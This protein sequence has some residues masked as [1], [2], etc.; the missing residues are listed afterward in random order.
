[1][2]L[3]SGFDAAAPGLTSGQEAVLDNLTAS[4][5]DLV[6]AGDVLAEGRLQAGDG[7]SIVVRDTTG[8]TNRLHAWKVSAGAMAEQYG[9]G[10]DI[11][12]V[13]ASG[14]NTRRVVQTSGENYFAQGT[15]L[16]DGKVHAM[17]TGK[18]QTLGHD[19]GTGL[20]AIGGTGG[21]DFGGLVASGAGAASASDDLATKAQTGPWEL[22][23]VVSRLTADW[24]TQPAGVSKRFGQSPCSV[25]F[26]A[27]G[28]TISD[29]GPTDP[30]DDSNVMP[31]VDIA[32]HS[33][34]YRLDVTLS[35]FTNWTSVAAGEHE[36][37]MIIE[38]IG[39]PGTLGGQVFVGVIYT[40]NTNTWT[41]YAYYLAAGATTATAIDAGD[42]LTGA[43]DELKLSLDITPDTA[44]LYW[45]VDY[46]LGGGWEGETQLGSQVNPYFSVKG[47]ACSNAAAGK[48]TG[49]YMAHWS[50]THSP[51][52]TVRVSDMVVS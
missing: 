48:T 20:L 42:N 31:G 49:V 26:G 51:A 17:G 11:D 28:V 12:T 32:H 8:A 34:T 27:T 7:A 3:S 9:T 39:P 10:A 4:G 6:A 35:D 23:E 18:D 38:K 16:P 14:M 33:H 30:H 5:S 2:G 41:V 40:K 50:V 19:A 29:G 37:A 25:T 43:P 22:A 21:V 13:L 46:G 1:M 36:Q 45:D 15:H 44:D 52:P 24:S 47:S